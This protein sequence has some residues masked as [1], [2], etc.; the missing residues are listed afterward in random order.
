MNVPSLIK[1]SEDVSSTSDRRARILIV[2]DH[3]L[4]REGLA[5]LLD[6]QSDMRCCGQSDGAVRAPAAIKEYSPDLVLLDLSLKD[7][8]G[9]DLLGMLVRQFPNLRV[10][11]LSQHDENTHAE[12]ALRHGAQG[13]VM[14]QEATQEVLMAIRTVLT[15]EIYLSHRMSVRLL[16]KLT[17]TPP[18]PQP[19]ANLT[20]RE[21]E[22][23]Q[24]VGG[25]LSTKEIARELNLSVKTVETYRE[26]LKSKLGLTSGVQLNEFAIKSMGQP[27][28]PSAP[29]A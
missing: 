22:V 8:D 13:Y 28:A 4:V 17:S 10:L 3:P 29:P 21:R 19:I 9:F 27:P 25:G 18:G 15:G 1:L 6:R 26:H 11:V 20:A 2:E 7:G 23:F 16:R 24:L 5:R 12:M 14:K